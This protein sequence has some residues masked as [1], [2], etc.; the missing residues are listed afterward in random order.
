MR[1]GASHVLPGLEL[2]NVLRGWVSCDVPQN[3][4]GGRIAFCG[5]VRGS[6]SHCGIAIYDEDIC[7]CRQLSLARQ[8]LP[9]FRFLLFSVSMPAYRLAARSFRT[10]PSPSCRRA[11]FGLLQNHAQHVVSLS[12]YYSPYLLHTCTPVYLWTPIKATIHG[13]PTHTHNVQGR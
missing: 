8:G 7:P 5:A 4:K 13:R 11:G 9:C 3:T 12:Q 2:T 1:A 10:D 6:L